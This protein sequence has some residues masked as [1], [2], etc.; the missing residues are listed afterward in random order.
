M[1]KRLIVL[2]LPLA[3]CVASLALAAE[4]SGEQHRGEIM[5]VD[6]GAKTITVKIVTNGTRENHIYKIVDGTTIIRDANQKVI[7]FGDLKDGQHISVVS[8]KVSGDRVAME[9]TIKAVK[10][11]KKK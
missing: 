11:S 2:A 7:G 10:S 6:T 1:L 9:I 4:P 5:S 3:L 8:K